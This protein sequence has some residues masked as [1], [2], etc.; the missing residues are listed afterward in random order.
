MTWKGAQMNYKA[1]IFDMDGTVLDTVTDLTTALNYTME[2]HGRRHNYTDHD[3]KEFFGSGVVVALTRAVAYEA[4]L[5]KSE[6][7]KVGTPDDPVSAKIDPGLI[8]ELKVTYQPYYELHCR[9]HTKPYT[10]IVPMIQTMKQAGVRTAVVSNK[11]D[12]A[13]QKL[14][15][16]H[17]AGVFDFALGQKDEIR[18]KPAPD[19]LEKCLEVLQVDRRECV[20][21][22]D[23]EIDIQT[24][25]NC[26]MDCI[27]VTWG[28]RS[29]TFLQ[30]HGASHIVSDPSEIK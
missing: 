21:I 9:D 14:C 6:L 3:T 18:R 4:G 22:G 23:S 17:F 24:A 13:V 20:Y 5:P 25:A 8:Q 10:G 7:V 16:Q 2:K 12:G 15:E 1:Y 19:M 26:A 11:P 29:R 30:A 27:S 28:F